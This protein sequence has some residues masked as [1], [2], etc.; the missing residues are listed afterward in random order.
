MSNELNMAERESIAALLR[1]GW[2]KRRI[3]KELGLH[4]DT[5][6]RHA[7]ALERQSAGLSP[8][9]CGATDSKPATAD[10]VANCAVQAGSGE[11]ATGSAAKQATPAEVATGNGAVQ[12]VAG[13]VA[14]GTASDLAQA[15]RS[16]CEPYRQVIEEKIAA[17]LSAQRIFQDLTAEHG[18]GGAYNA[19]KRI[20]RRLSATSELPF[21][22]MEC[23]PGEQAQADFGSGA[24]IIGISAVP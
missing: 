8:E 5:V 19:V 7:R 14:T 6:R 9:P 2:S 17:G 13:E 11:V 1:Q 4:R 16:T 24:P 3:A 23:A 22:R 20:V 12:T 18:Y 10:E 21:R 15:G